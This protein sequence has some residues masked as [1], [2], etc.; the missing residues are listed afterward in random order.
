MIELL[1]G[2]TLF[3]VVSVGIYQVL[4]QT[5][6]RSSKAQDV[7]T[8]STE[9]RLGFNRMVRDT[10]EAQN[11]IGPTATSFQIETDFNGDGAIQPSPADITGDY[12]SLRFTFNVA[13]TGLGT[14]TATAGDSTEVLMEGV[15]CVRKTDNMCQ[16]VFTYSSSRLEYDTNSNGVT[17]ATE[18]DAATGVGNGNGVLDGAEVNYIDAV[19]FQLRTKAG[20]TTSTFY[21]EAQLRNHR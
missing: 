16:T 3:A 14:V 13:S 8:T 6:Q 21:A 2:V 19:A 7:A 4:F 17:S 10:R 1:V 11:L 5:A 20:T 15:D 12:E 18:L 9:A